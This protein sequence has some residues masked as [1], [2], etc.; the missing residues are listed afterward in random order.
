MARGE[1]A[2]DA[3]AVA[4][5]RRMVTVD[6]VAI[7][8]REVGSAS[9]PAIV[10]AHAIGHGGG[11]F[12]AFEAAMR[13]RWRVVTF[14]WPGHGASGGDARA[15][16]ARR[17]AELLEGLLDALD[18]DRP[19][20]FGN[21][22]GGAASI[23]LAAQR[24]RRARALVLCNP[25]GLDPGGL[26]ARL[27]MRWLASRFRRGVEGDPDFARWYARY[28]DGILLGD[29]VA[30]RRDAIV[31]AG[32]ESAPRLVEAWTSFAAP[33]ADLRAAA[34]SLR[35]P[36]FVGWAMRDR[37]VRWS[38]NRA[39]VEAIPG[40]RVARF[41]RS[42]HVLF[43]EEGAAFNAAVAPFLDALA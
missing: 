38:R 6:G 30:A 19:V 17:Y 35:V 28:Y 27:F 23:A 5:P 3:L 21:S 8:V 16:S 13:A 43:L 2:R 4:E 40:V 37:L 9:A 18:L 39:A 36:V 32:Y 7:A 42:G 34:R 20:L 14:D 25:G 24:P 1:G 12:A 41:E 15:A 11:D 29:A 26:L 10:C 31:R 33:E 22:I